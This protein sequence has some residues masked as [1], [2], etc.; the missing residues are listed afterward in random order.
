M[1]RPLAEL[2]GPSLTLNGSN[3]GIQLIFI[4]RSADLIAKVSLLPPPGLPKT[5]RILA[6]PVGGGG[7]EVEAGQPGNQLQNLTWSTSTDS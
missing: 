6:T 2:R 7:G 4:S 3:S 5:A 1:C